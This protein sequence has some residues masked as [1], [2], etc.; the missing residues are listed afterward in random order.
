MPLLPPTNPLDSP[1]I[2]RRISYFTTNNDATVCARVCKAWFDHFASAIWHTLDFDAHKRLDKIDPKT[3]AR[4][5]QHIR[6]VKNVKKKNHILVL[7]GSNARNLRELSIT[8]WPSEFYAYVSDLLRRVNVSIERLKLSQPSGI[9]TY[10]AVDSL[11]YPA[12]SR[13]ASK[14]RSLEIHGL[15][16][17]RDAFSILL[18]ECPSLTILDIKG[19]TLDPLPVH[20]K[21]YEDLYQHYGV[22]NLT[23]GFDQVFNVDG[24]DD[25]PSLLVHFPS[26]RTWE[27]SGITWHLRTPIGKIRDEVTRHC[28]FLRELRTRSP[29]PVTSDMIAQAFEDLEVIGVENGYLSAEIIAASLNHQGTLEAFVTYYDENILNRSGMAP[30]VENRLE[31]AWIVQSIPRLCS[32]LKRFELPLYEMNMDDIENAKWGCKHLEVLY[33]RIKDLN[34]KE[35]VD[36]AVQLWKEGR[37]ATIIG[38][39][40]IKEEET[41]ASS[42]PQSGI[43][44]PLED[45]SVEARVARHLLKFKYLQRVW[46]GWKVHEVHQ[47][48]VRRHGVF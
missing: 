48:Y 47:D 39:T 12:S 13:A 17:T 4:Y 19:S 7:I 9:P 45:R 46:L 14:L 43:D 27:M 33:I 11:F 40:R 36:R 35:K 37:P 22:T 44:I 24:P 6:V 28:R 5:G 42:S 23:A 8:T 25:V 41:S 15:T 34:T 32:Q 31:T 10:F 29:T 38:K 20:N 30:M 21:S 16:M 26:L 18:R 3:F 2:L 1:E